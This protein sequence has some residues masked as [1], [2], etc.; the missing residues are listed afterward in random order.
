MLCGH[1][2]TLKPLYSKVCCQ[3]CRR[4]DGGVRLGHAG[5]P[6]AAR[7]GLPAHIYSFFLHWTDEINATLLLLC[8]LKLEGNF[9]DDFGRLK[10]VLLFEN[11]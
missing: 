3:R 5:K 11:D 6:F 10:L 8:I 9:V 7:A 1:E 2:E 4:K